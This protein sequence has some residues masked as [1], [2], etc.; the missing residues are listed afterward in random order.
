MR[1]IV[2][3]LRTVDLTGEVPYV[4]AEVRLMTVKEIVLLRNR[5]TESYGPYPVCGKTVRP[6]NYRYVWEYR[7][8][9]GGRVTDSLFFKPEEL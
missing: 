4:H 5:L 9:T 2:K 1:Y 3:H 6:F 7:T 8:V